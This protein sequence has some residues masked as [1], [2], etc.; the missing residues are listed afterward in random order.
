MSEFWQ[1]II[2]SLQGGWRTYC[3]EQTVNAEILID[4]L[5]S[6]FAGWFSHQDQSTTPKRLP[7]KWLE[8][9]GDTIERLG[10][11]VDLRDLLDDTQLLGCVKNWLWGELLTCANEIRRKQL[12]VPHP[13]QLL[14]QCFQAALNGC[15][16]S[17]AVT[18]L[19]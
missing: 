15:I 13:R 1:E 12:Q 14:G 7:Q 16:D 9:L 4:N 3:D 6:L 19:R 18:G 2:Q 5:R 11:Y 10:E 17:Y 8:Q